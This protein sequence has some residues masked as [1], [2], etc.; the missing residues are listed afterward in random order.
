[1]LRHQPVNHTIGDGTDDVEFHSND[2]VLP[3]VRRDGTSW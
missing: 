3:D 1:M 2:S